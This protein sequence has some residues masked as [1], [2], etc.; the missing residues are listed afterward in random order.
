MIETLIALE[1]AG[2]RCGVA[3]WSRIGNGVPAITHSV[4]NG[5]QEHAAQ[6]LPMVS[7]HL[8][9]AGLRPADLNAIA[10]GQGPG[11]FTGLRVACGI[12]QGM[13]LALDVPVVAVSTHAAVADRVE[14]TVEPQIVAVAM[15]ARM[16]EVYVTVLLLPGQ[17]E[18]D[19]RQLPQS[20]QSAVQ[21]AAAPGGDRNVEAAASLAP[22][23]LHWAAPA[24]RVLAGPLLMA[25]ADLPVWL[26]QGRQGWLAQGKGARVAWLIGEAWAAYGEKLA[27]P[28]G[29]AM[30]AAQAPCVARVARLGALAWRAGKGQD[31]ADARL[32]YVRDKVA[33]T[34][35]ERAIGLGGN[36]RMASALGENA[37]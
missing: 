2:S 17:C 33:F 18:A 7:Q 3:L 23:L 19:P 5:V 37:K 10:F 16:A 22:P 26:A 9:S 25:A 6:L 21:W 20:N 28:T 8:E 31:A 29:W 27:W 32:V 15:D 13:G 1:T 36:P 30:H 24:P 4:Y 35:A 34:M 11:A 14:R 12:A